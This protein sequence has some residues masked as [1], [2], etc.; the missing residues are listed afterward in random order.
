M[1]LF[2]SYD[3]VEPGVNSM[4]TVPTPTQLT[5]DAK[6]AVQIVFEDLGGICRLTEWA[7]ASPQNLTAFYTQIWP[8]IIPKDIKSE[9]TGKDGKELTVNIVKFGVNAVDTDIEDAVC[10]DPYA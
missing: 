9:L 3:T 8:R 6:A 5:R 10:S 4:A 1:L 2:S 7:N